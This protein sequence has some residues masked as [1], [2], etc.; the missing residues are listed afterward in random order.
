MMVATPETKL[1]LEIRS[2]REALPQ[3]D[4]EELAAIG[5]LLGKLA[6]LAHAMELELQILRDMEDGRELRT[7]IRTAIAAQFPG[8]DDSDLHENVIFS[9]FGRMG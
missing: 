5:V 2:I 3:A 7:G 4:V 6:D 8:T 1:S 9:Q